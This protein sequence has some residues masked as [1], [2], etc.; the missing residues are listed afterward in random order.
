[1]EKLLSG[2]APVDP[3]VG[4]ENPYYYRNKVCAEFRKLKNGTIISGRYQE[5]THNVI[6]TKGCKIEDQRADAIIQDITGL[7]RS[8]KMMIYNEDS[9]Y[10]LIR[11][12]LIRTA[13]QTGQI[14][15]IIVTASPV[16]P[17]K[18]NFA[19]A[20]LKL[21][22]E[23]TTIVQNIN[24]K[25]TN[26]VLGD[27][28]QVIYGKGYI[29]DVLCGKRFR[30][31]PGSFYQINSVQTEKLYNKAIKYADL[32]KKETVIEEYVSD[33]ESRGVFL[34]CHLRWD[35]TADQSKHNTNDHKDHRTLYRK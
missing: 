35:K 13:H 4:M 30:L 3:I 15:V 2:F 1:M 29:E 23:I 28:N 27:R 7:F 10:G 17:S 20:L 8:F 32:K 31:S 12:V 24:T 16:F 5:G 22:P 25:D 6:E 19:N 14:M 18:K 34:R 21:H 26:M 11:H 9:G 33:E